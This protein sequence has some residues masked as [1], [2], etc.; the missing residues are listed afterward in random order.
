MMKISKLIS[1]FRTNM[2]IR[3]FKPLQKGCFNNLISSSILIVVSFCFLHGYFYLTK[4]FG[5]SN[6]FYIAERNYGS[7]QFLKASD[8]NDSTYQYSLFIELKK[9]WKTY[10]KYPGNSGF[11]PKFELISSKN[12]KDFS[13]SWP[14]PGVFYEGE[15]KIYGFQEKLHLPITVYPKHPGNDIHFVLRLEIGFCKDICIPET[16]YLKSVNARPASEVQNEELLSYIRRVP[17]ELENSENY[18]SCKVEK[19]KGKLDLIAKFNANFFKGKKHI[20]DAIFNYRGEEIWFS[21]KNQK[22]EKGIQ[23]FSMTLNH[24]AEKS[25]LLNKSKIE[26]TILTQDNGFIL[27]GCRN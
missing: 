27:D 13:V 15:T 17:I 22:S 14:A 11:T 7:I 1:N 4:A 25:I 9:N 3:R 12:L 24:I 23:I 6:D 21:N 16:V 20:K 26:V 18:V 10:W 2:L 19:D 8:I 5:Q